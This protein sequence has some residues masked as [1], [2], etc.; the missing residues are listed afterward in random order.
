MSQ[1]TVRKTGSLTLRR[2]L[3]PLIFAA[4]LVTL[5]TQISGAGSNPGQQTFGSGEAL[6]VVVGGNSTSGYRV[7]IY[8][9]NQLVTTRGLAGKY[10]LTVFPGTSDNQPSG[11]NILTDP[12]VVGSCQGPF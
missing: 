11:P 5:S 1:L 7:E 9:R 6:H 2:S 12:T 8:D 10:D 3:R 4:G